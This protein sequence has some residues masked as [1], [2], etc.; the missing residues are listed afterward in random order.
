MGVAGRVVNSASLKDAD[1]APSVSHKLRLFTDS[2]Q[3]IS[4]VVVFF[5]TLLYF[6]PSFYASTV[7]VKV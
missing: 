5:F 3:I 1:P 6:E 7:R 2:S 4:H